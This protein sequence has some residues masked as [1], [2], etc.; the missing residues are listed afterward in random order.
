MVGC[1]G[2]TQPDRR[3]A[4]AQ[5]GEVSEICRGI[6]DG[7]RRLMEQGERGNTPFE[8]WTRA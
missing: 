2:L 6:R 4:M 3:G 7:L 5:E 1:D 8:S